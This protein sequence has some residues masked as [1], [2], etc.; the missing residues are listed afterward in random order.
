MHIKKL[1]T[2]FQRLLEVIYLYSKIEIVEQ[3]DGEI[4]VN[5]RYFGS[6]RKGDRF[7]EASGKVLVL[8]FK[9]S[10]ILNINHSSAQ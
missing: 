9:P 5:E 2:I 4:E 7:H 1:S 3:L 10:F 6:I 8:I